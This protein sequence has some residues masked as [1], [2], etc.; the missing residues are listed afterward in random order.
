MQSVLLEG[1][2]PFRLPTVA[3]VVSLDGGIKDNPVLRLRTEQGPEV[4]L[5]LEASAL[6]TLL[7][8]AGAWRMHP[9]NPLNKRKS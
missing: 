9:Q 2:G 6:A 1:S 7:Q 5:P 8:L 3:S 4:W